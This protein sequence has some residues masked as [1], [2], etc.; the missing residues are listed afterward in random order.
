MFFF[1][2]YFFRLERKDTAICLAKKR[3][4][5]DRFILDVSN[6]SA[7]QTKV[8]DSWFD[9]SLKHH[10]DAE[11]RQC[12]QVGKIILFGKGFYVW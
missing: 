4:K 9:V 6:I 3:M 12:C 1:V 8:K 7:Q 5:G 11:L 2:Y 10:R